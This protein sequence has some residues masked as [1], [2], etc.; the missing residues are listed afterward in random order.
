MSVITISREIGTGGTDLAKEVA[1]RLGYGYVDKQKIQ[2]IMNEYGLI[3]FNDFYDKE[4]NIWDK[5][6]RVTEEIIDL[7]NRILLG[8]AKMGRSVILGRGGFIALREYSDALNVMIQAPLKVRIDAVMLR[9]N[10]TDAAKA[11]KQLIQH[12]KSRQAFIEYAYRVEW[13]NKDNFDLVIDAGK[14]D[15]SLAIDLIILAAGHLDGKIKAPFKSTADIEDDKI[16]ESAI[17]KYL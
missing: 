8:I 11:E 2:K 7:L 6:Y 13:K 17:N 10:I 5:Y 15:Q 9:D 14:I 16:I 1:K 3:D 4:L 12:Q